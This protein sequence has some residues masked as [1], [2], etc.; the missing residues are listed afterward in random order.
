MGNAK[1]FLLVAVVAMIAVPALSHTA[2]A[3]DFWSEII[4]GIEEWFSMSPFKGIFETPEKDVSEVYIKFYPSVYT[5]EP[6]GSFDISTR[7]ALIE[8]FAGAIT[9][10]ATSGE[11]LLEQKDSQTKIHVFLSE[12]MS[13]ENIE[14]GRFS[15]ENIEL[16]IV[17]GNW[18]ERTTGGS[19]EFVDFIGSLSF[20][21]DHIEL[22]G[23]VS[24]I[25]KK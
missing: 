2:S 19:A 4:K 13:I 25:K 11:I 20:F 22:A 18:T 17:K 1:L 23:N 9:F 21:E 6:S 10:N 14:I 16:E 24:K 3:E 7:G 8:N 5:F 15:V 12:N